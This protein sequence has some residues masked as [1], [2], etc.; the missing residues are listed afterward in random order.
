MRKLIFAAAVATATLGLAACGGKA[1]TETEDTVTEM[2]DD[3]DAADDGAGEMLGD[4]TPPSDATIMN[5]AEDAAD[6]AVKT[7]D[8][9][10]DD[11]LDVVNDAEAAGAE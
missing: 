3:A 7:T 5:D 10:G 8:E 2:V 4:A 1:E 6:Q 9:V 11:A